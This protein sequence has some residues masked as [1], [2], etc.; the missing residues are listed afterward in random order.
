[1][2][3]HRTILTNI[4]QAVRASEDVLTYCRTNFGRGLAVHVG[5]YPDGV[6]DV[7]GSPFRWIQ[8]RDESEAEKTD[9]TFSVLLT[10]GGCVKG[11]D[12]EGVINNVVAER[13]ASANGLV[14]NGGNKIVEDLRDIILGIVRNAKAGAAVAR[15][16]R[17]ENDISHFP[18]EWA[19]VYVDYY[20]PES[21]T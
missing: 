5:A 3:S 19:N 8:P 20:E 16:R 10:V 14:V 18:L 15:I 21:L 1:M 2:T 12:G 7:D 11:P 4:G 6:P 17:D 13:T 9:E